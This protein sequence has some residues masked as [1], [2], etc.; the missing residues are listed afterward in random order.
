MTTKLIGSTGSANYNLSL[1]RLAL[2]DYHATSEPVAVRNGKE[3]TYQ[4]IGAN[5]DPMYPATLRVGVYQTN[6]SSPAAS[7]SEKLSTY[8]V[9]SDAEGKVT[10]A[11]KLEVTIAVKMEGNDLTDGLDLGTFAQGIENAISVLL[12]NTS[13]TWNVTAY[14]TADMPLIHLGR[15]GVIDLPGTAE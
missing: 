4:Y 6:G 11:K 8:V 12:P 15:L 5:A 1:R 9:K 13:G 3:Q 2:A 14:N 10:S 7:I